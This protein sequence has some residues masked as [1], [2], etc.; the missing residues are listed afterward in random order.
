MNRVLGEGPCSTYRKEII[1]EMDV[2]FPICVTFNHKI[3]IGLYTFFG[4]M[5]NILC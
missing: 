2:I 4:M 5:T 1:T 3:T